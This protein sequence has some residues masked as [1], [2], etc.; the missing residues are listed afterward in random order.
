MAKVLFARYQIIIV[1]LAQRLKCDA[2]NERNN[3]K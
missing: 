1:E 3:I 2:Y